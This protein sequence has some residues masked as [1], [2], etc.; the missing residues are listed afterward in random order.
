MILDM[1]FKS[2]WTGLNLIELTHETE[3][4]YAVKKIKINLCWR[5]IGR[6]VPK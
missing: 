3:F 1:N 5:V 2:L 6:N 4:I